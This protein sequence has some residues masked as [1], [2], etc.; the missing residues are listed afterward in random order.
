MVYGMKMM[1]K[2]NK[3]SKMSKKTKYNR[4]R[5]LNCTLT[6]ES[7]NNPGYFKYDVTIGEK[8]G[9]VHTQPAYGKDMQDALSRLINKE[10]TVKV[11]NRATNNPFLVFLIWVALM[12]WPAIL[13]DTTNQPVFIFY[14]FAVVFGLVGAGIW[15]SSYINKK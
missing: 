2:M 1:N 14:G 9:T 5:A 15:W 11:E 8:D 13:M 3:L 12:G 7:T 6:D 4:R 10:R